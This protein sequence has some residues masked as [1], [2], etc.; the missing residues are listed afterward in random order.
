MCATVGVAHEASA[1]AAVDWFDCTGQFGEPC[2]CQEVFPF[3]GEHEGICPDSTSCLD[4]QAAAIEACFQWGGINAYVEHFDCT[5]PKDPP[6]DFEFRC[7]VF[8]PN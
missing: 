2:D 7:N 6:V 8:I 4:A 5:D 1:R 3:D